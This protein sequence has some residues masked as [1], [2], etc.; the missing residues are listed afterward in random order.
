MVLI[1]SK[2]QPIPGFP[3]YFVSR[4]GGVYSHHRWSKDL[5]PVK[6]VTTPKGYKVVNIFRDGK[7][8]I[9]RV[10]VLVLTTFRGP[11]PPGHQCR[12]RDG[13]PGNNR[14]GNLKWGT[15]RENGIDRIRHGTQRGGRPLARGGN[16]NQEI[17]NQ[18]RAAR[19]AG[20]KQRDVAAQFDVS[21]ATVW[22]IV[23]GRCWV[24][25][26]V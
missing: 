2:P 3:G 1:M 6:P 11:C 19:A 9:V 22:N 25:H 10:H 26:G 5:R 23:N 18:I 24:R 8:Q 21:Q 17:A 16:L 20:G 15:P 13:D 4:D 14:L 7:R 12:H